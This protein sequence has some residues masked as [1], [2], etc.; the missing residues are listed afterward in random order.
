MTPII[1]PQPLVPAVAGG[2]TLDDFTIDLDAMTVT[3]PEQIT[4]TISA[5]TRTARF[6]T[7]CDRCPVRQQCTNAKS[8][9]VIKVHPNHALLAAARVFADTDHFDT[10]YRQHRPMIERTIA[11]L[12]RDN[13][14]RVRFRGIE[15]NR[16]AWSVRCAA[17]NLKR[18]L[19]LGLVLDPT[20][21]WTI[22]PA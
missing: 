14:R 2:Y 10:T 8:G 12:V 11:W 22:N 18:L 1:K 5:K 13:H 6:G 19:N 7:A 20:G 21:T 9:R 17:I 3:C 4:V 15:A 16:H